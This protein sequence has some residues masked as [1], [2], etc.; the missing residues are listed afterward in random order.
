M[1]ILARMKSSV[2]R[3][4]T[5][6]AVSSLAGGCGDKKDKASSDTG[7]GDDKDDKKDKESKKD[8][9]DPAKKSKSKDDSS[10]HAR[11]ID[12]ARNSLGRMTRGAIAAFE[13]ESMGEGGEIAHAL[14]KSATPVPEKVP[15]AGESYTPKS[16]AGVDFNAGDEKTG[17]PCLKFSGDSQIHFQYSY[18]V[19]GT[20]KLAARGKD[21]ANGDASFLELCAE[22]DFEPGGKTTLVCF[23]GQVKTDRLQMAPKMVELGEDE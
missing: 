20:P 2:V 12:K 18:A 21:V 9:K 19:G 10:K 14:C 4:L 16:D 11:E 22:A 23:T 15:S 6:L 3:L 7:K 13:R 1:C 8:D 17:W 5:F